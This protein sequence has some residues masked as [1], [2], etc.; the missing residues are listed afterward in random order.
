MLACGI[1]KKEIYRIL[2][3]ENLLRFL[4]AFCPAYAL[5]CFYHSRGFVN[6]MAL[7]L[8]ILPF[9]LVIATV[10]LLIA[11]MLPVLFFRK[12]YPVAFR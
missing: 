10:L 3:V 1:T 5:M 9:L 2:F 11:A 8:K 4:T 6:N 12:K 7:V